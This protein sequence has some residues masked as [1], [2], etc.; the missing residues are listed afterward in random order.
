LRPHFPGGAGKVRR[1][2]ARY[3]GR[4]HGRKQK[5][6]KHKTGRQQIVM[7][8]SIFQ[9]R[10]GISRTNQSFAGGD[11]EYETVRLVE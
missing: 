9:V 7:H 3:E 11:I 5:C 1:A 2:T 10:G 8:E 4:K 6:G